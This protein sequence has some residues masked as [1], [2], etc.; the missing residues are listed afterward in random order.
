[1]GPVL[2]VALVVSCASEQA[3]D[4]PGACSVAE[5]ARAIDRSGEPSPPEDLLQWAGFRDIGEL[6]VVE[7]DEECGMD[8][9]ARV[10][11]RGSAAEIDAALD[12]AGFVD[13]PSP[14]LSVFDAPLDGIDFDKLT[15]VVSSGQ[16]AWENDAGE[17]ITRVY[18]RGRTGV[19]DQELLH[20]WAYTT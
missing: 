4:A 10:A 8:A 14:G 11:L 2:A 15:N 1:M 3:T 9:A 19:G 13:S 7:A 12:A 16:Q 20:L 18:V 5:D 6:E 17:Q